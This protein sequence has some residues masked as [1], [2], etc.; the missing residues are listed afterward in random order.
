MYSQVVIYNVYDNIAILFGRKY[1]CGLFIC[2]DSEL[3]YMP[4]I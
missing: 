2:A 1:M 3:Q 4:I